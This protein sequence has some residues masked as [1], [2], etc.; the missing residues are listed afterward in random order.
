VIDWLFRA[1]GF[2]PHGMCLIW[3]QNVLA[4]HGISDAV[5]ALSYFSIPAVLFIILRQRPDFN[6][7][8]VLHLFSLFIIACGITHVLS[9]LTL[10]EPLYNLSSVAKVLTAIVSA[11]TAIVLW[12][13]LPRVLATPSHQELALSNHQLS[14]TAAQLTEA[15]QARARFLAMMSHEIRTPLTGI[16]GFTEI[17]RREPLEARARQSLERIATA[18]RSLQRLLGDILEFSRMDQGTL[19]VHEE[20]FNLRALVDQI[21]L[22][23]GGT[24]EAKGLDLCIE[25]ADDIPAQVMTDPLRLR[26]VL[27]NLVSNAIRYTE[28]GQIFVTISRVES[29]RMDQGSAPGHQLEI[30]VKDTG[31][32]IPEHQREAI[33]DAF[34]QVDERGSRVGRTENGAGLGLAIVRK[35]VDALGGEIR[36]QSAVGFGSEF[37]VTLPY[38]H[39]TEQDSDETASEILADK[40]LPNF[41]RIFLADDVAMNRDLFADLLSDISEEVVVVTDG[42]QALDI[43]SV[44]SFDAAVIDIQMPFMDGLELVRALRISDDLRV[45]AL[46]VV[47]LSA[48]AYAEDRARALEAGMNSY[49]TKP[50]SR[51]SLVRGL[52]TA[53][54]QRSDRSGPGAR[55]VGTRR[56][57]PPSQSTAPSSD[58]VFDQ[59]FFER[60]TAVL[61]SDNVRAYLDK[62]TT[63]LI[64]RRQTLLDARAANDYATISRL[65]HA[66]A[67]AGG[68]LGF[69][70]LYAAAREVETA[71]GSAKG[72]PSDITDRLEVLDAALEDALARIPEL[73]ARD[74]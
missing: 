26:Q 14:E 46:P 1:E 25:I 31:P 50:A 24:A 16:I 70:A 67:S 18:S 34:V 38:R 43:L 29:P 32:G 33:F 5:I 20:P 71:V 8:G 44:E 4:L 22:E 69:S 23:V 37:V 68:N 63:E 15:S 39:A 53:T 45:R 51:E 54:A 73:M 65:A 62:L 52:A 27:L 30:S 47:G 57:E 17:M 61:G 64:T 58:E 19:M 2:A 3:D 42:Q 49:V 41:G 13:L 7:Y 9:I 21:E 35:V 10:W 59:E 56:V 6:L 74:I 28:R 60:Q 48:A 66:I 12:P 72:V 11:V 55:R 36:L 40:V